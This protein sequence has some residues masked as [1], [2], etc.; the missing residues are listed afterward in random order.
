MLRPTTIQ[1]SGGWSALSSLP[2]TQKNTSWGTLNLH[3]R[4]A[5]FFL[6]IELPSL[7]IPN[8]VSIVSRR[9]C[10][11]LGHGLFHTYISY[12]GPP[13][14]RLLRRHH[15][16]PL[17]SPAQCSESPAMHFE[18]RHS[19]INVPPQP[20]PPEWWRFHPLT[21]FPRHDDDFPILYY[22][23]RLNLLQTPPY[24][25]HTQIEKTWKRY[26]KEKTLK[27]PTRAVKN[28]RDREGSPENR[29]RKIK[30]F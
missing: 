8:T 18:R 27:L 3:R 21:H 6:V 15:D 28:A 4:W 9:S 1:P 17:D 5:S 22:P 10:S 24:P 13:P 12:G 14:H 30:I 26:K 25:I 19:G 7:E 2:G 23:I 20:I 11:G 29:W 16:G